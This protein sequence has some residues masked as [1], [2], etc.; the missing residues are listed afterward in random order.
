MNLIHKN[1]DYYLNSLI[2]R[3]NLSE[4]YTEEQVK[5]YVRCAQDPEYFIEKYVRINSLDHGFVPFKLRGY[6]KGLIQT[7]HKNR[8]VV[9]L[10]PRQS[11]KC[12]FI[13]T[14]VTVRNKI[15]GEIKEITIGDFYENIKNREQTV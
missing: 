6:Q 12:V 13:N 1:K 8:R 5:E 7:F 3:T 15:T 2:K 4:N 10:S 14:I 9:L 11:G